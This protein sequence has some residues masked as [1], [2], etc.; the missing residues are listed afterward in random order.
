M[1]TKIQG[2]LG[3][4]DNLHQRALVRQVM[5]RDRDVILETP[6]PSIYHDFVSAGRLHLVSRD[7]RLRTQAKNVQR[8]ASLGRFSG[9]IYGQQKATRSMK[10]WYSH[11]DLRATGSFVRAMLA[12]S[13]LDVADCDF[14]LPVHPQW[15]ERANAMIARWAPS[16]PIMLYRPLVERTEWRGCAQRNP[17][18]RAYA[19]LV[20][21]IR[22]DYFVVSVA[23]L[24]DGAEWTVGEA[25]DADVT[26]H[27]GELEFETLA[28]VA[29]MSALVFGAPGFAVVLGQALQRPTVCVF[30]GHER[31]AYYEAGAAVARA[32]YLG[33]D[34][35]RACDCF[36]HSHACDKRIDLDAATHRLMRFAQSTRDQTAITSEATPIPC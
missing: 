10:V 1:T 3:L 14:R 6:W 28:A 26:L 9:R 31:S 29:S 20:R 21:A 13:R 19:E 8:E 24:Q 25:I 12:N 32:P 27:R 34:P 18:H 15:I 35:I 4:G 30:G 22:E 16:R 7:S 17:D 33:I 23:D 5:A 36:S 2:M 11:A